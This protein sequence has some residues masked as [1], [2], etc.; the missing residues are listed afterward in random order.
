MK[1]NFFCSFYYLKY[2]KSYSTMLTNYNDF[3]FTSGYELDNIVG[4]QFH[5]EKS[6]IW[7]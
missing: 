6:S 5:P 1:I 7:N 3:K 2:N 4:V